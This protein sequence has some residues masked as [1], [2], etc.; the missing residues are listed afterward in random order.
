M[1]VRRDSDD[2]A[3][4]KTGDLGAE[5]R[6]S[7]HHRAIRLQSEARLQDDQGV[8]DQK[9]QSDAQ[10]TVPP[11]SFLSTQ[12]AINVRR[13]SG[14]AA[15]DKT[16]VPGVERRES[17][18]H[19]AVRFQRE[20]CLQAD[21][22]ISD[23]KTQN[24]AHSRHTFKK[25]A[26]SLSH[27]QSRGVNRGSLGQHDRGISASSCSSSGG[28]ADDSPPFTALHPAGFKQFCDR[29]QA[30]VGIHDSLYDIFDAADAA[31]AS[32]TLTDESVS[33]CPFGH[34]GA[35]DGSGVSV[36]M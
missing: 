10:K 12:N 8:S 5:G 14:V 32:E 2:E 27:F 4:E 34:C 33:D 22:G 35:F 13:H 1:N 29:E 21:R 25:V 7:F 20:A 3:H 17:F 6:D 23:H 19:R 28:Q 26:S 24:V 36:M 31:S 15:G 30:D 18:H 16:S 11:Y 9:F